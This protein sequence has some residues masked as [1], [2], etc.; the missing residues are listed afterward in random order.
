MIHL[1]WILKS[2]IM[3]RNA[4]NNKGVGGYLKDVIEQI[5]EVDNLAFDNKNKNEIILSNKKQEYENKINI[6]RTE[7]LDAAKKSARRTA[8][9]TEVFILNTE[10]NHDAKV[11]TISSAMDKKYKQAEK[12]LIQKIFNK[13]F[14]L[15]G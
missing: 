12:D 13:L 3:L 4:K 2:A 8:E 14:V 7:K 6:Y 9:E 11:Q 5:I 15:E 1:N 10:K